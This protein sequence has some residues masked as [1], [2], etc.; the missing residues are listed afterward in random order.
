LAE[1]WR[2]GG[3][4]V[5]HGS[6]DVSRL[7]RA[8]RLAGHRHEQPAEGLQVLPLQRAHR[9][10]VVWPQRVEQTH[11]RE[12]RLRN[13]DR[14]SVRLGRLGGSGSRARNITS[15]LEKSWCPHR[16]LVAARRADPPKRGAPVTETKP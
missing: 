5:G 3:V 12:A 9:R 6:R 15:T 11:R 7:S 10:L 16:Q 2:E 14:V 8:E 1:L 13:T 4:D